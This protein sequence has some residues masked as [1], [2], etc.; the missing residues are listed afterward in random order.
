[1]TSEKARKE[2]KDAYYSIQQRVSTAESFRTILCPAI[3]D[4][5][6]LRMKSSISIAFS[7]HLN[8]T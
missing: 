6:T 5:W 7:V 1:M 8:A 4:W 3:T 2:H